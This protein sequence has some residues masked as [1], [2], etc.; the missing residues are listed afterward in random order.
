MSDSRETSLDGVALAA[1]KAGLT[2]TCH[3]LVT[4]G[5]VLVIRDPKEPETIEVFAKDGK[6]RLITV[7]NGGFVRTLADSLLDAIRIAGQ[8]RRAR[9]TTRR[10]R[11]RKKSGLP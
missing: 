7:S 11:A 4:G 1:V 2:A 9:T 5:V 8:M 10:K 3:P 6:V